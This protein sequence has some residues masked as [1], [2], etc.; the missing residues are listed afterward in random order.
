[1]RRLPI[2]R[3]C[4]CVQLRSFFFESLSRII[5]DYP[6]LFENGSGEP[7]TGVRPT[8]IW[9]ELVDK[10]CRGDRTKWDYFLQMGLIEFLNT[11]A[12]YKSTKKE[13][14]KRLEQAANK[15]Y[16]TY[17]VAVLNEML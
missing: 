6:I 17:I 7:T 14:S 15:G 8:L 16:Q 12:F 10:L 5:E 13:Q 1:M 9:L 4:H 11:V 2:V 3:F